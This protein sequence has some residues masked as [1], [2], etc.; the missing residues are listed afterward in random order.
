[1]SRIKA[2]LLAVLVPFAVAVATAT[3]ANAAVVTYLGVDNSVTNF[4]QMTN[5][6]AAAANFDAAVSGA[7]TITFETPVPSGV[8][9]TGGSIINSSNSPCGTLCGFN[10]TPG[11]AYFYSL[12]GGTSTFTFTTPISAFGMYITGLQ[13]G[14][15]GPE[16]LTFSDGSS[17][18]LTISNATSGAGAFLGFTDFGKMITSLTY[19]ASNDIIAFD[20]VQFASAAAVPEPSILPLF[21]LGIGLIGMGLVT[22]RRRKA[23][24]I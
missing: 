6:Q 21:G 1:M 13:T 4:S 2:T 9:I 17:Q 20:D 11:G 14:F 8:S 15:V 12:Y 10:T 16:T 22:A 3:P 18:T 23:R 5:A 24:A 7:T 19:N